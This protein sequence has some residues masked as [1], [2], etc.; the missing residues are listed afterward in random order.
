MNENAEPTETA[1][2]NRDTDLIAAENA[3]KRAAIKARLKA[4]Q[5]GMGI[6]I[7]RE[8]QVVEVQPDTDTKFLDALMEEEIA[9]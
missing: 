7:W 8:G 2:A 5:F 6:M 9:E 4:K 3:L 1:I